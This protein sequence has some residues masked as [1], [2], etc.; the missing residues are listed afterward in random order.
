M[1]ALVENLK[2]KWHW[3]SAQTSFQRAPILTTFRLIAWWIRCLIGI[4]AT[5]KLARWNLRMFL[6]ARWKGVEKLI[7]VFRENYEPELSYLE[8]ALS[9][10]ET[11]VDVGANL[12]IYALVASR[13]VG[14]SGRVIAFE[15]SPGSFALLEAN[16]KL[17]G[18]T[19]VQISPAA[20]SD[21]IGK[22]FLYDGLDPSQ[23][24]LGRD[25]RL[26]ANGEEVTTQS[27]DSALAQ[28][29]VARV[30]VIK[31]DVEG[32]EELVLRGANKLIAAHRP[33]VIFE[34]NQEASARL[35]LSP[36]GT[37]DLLRG[38]GYEFFSVQDNSVHEAK[39]LPMLGNV[40]AI[41]GTRPKHEMNR[42]RQADSKPP[43]TRAPVAL[44]GPASYGSYAV[45]KRIGKID[46]T[47]E[48]T[49]KCVL[50]LGCG[51]GCYTEELAS[52]AAYVCGVDIQMSHLKAFKQS[53]PRVQ[54]AAENL[55]F[56]PKSFDVVTMIEVLEHTDS[57]REALKECFRVLKPGGRLVLFVPNKLYPFESHPCQVGGFAIGPDIPLVSWFPEILRKRLCHA[58]IYTRKRLFSIALGAGFQDLKSGYIFPPLD[59]FPLPFKESYRRV[60][61]LL[62]NSPLARFGV[63]IYAVLQ[64]PGATL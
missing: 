14:P 53:I 46:E 60:A 32:A 30:H 36:R 64:K 27:L 5:V 21:K 31:M 39:S 59:S 51:N 58:R 16:I 48:L 57:D 13:I 10:R 52:R 33:T 28:T 11:F 18:L 62:E 44:G 26:E 49:G 43:S 37:W 56:A 17:N 54:A 1:K 63:S 34:I 25:V 7:F 40:V 41:Y 38:L 9:P 45:K 50:D 15:P 19:N 2:R 42:Q 8:R 24:S 23:N 3:L 61:C 29:S 4:G 12:G 55:P 20:V 47:L 22:A 35:G 6:P